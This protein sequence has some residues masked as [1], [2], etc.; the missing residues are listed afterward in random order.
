MKKEGDVISSNIFGAI[1]AFAIG[2]LLATLSYFVLKFVLRKHPKYYIAAQIFKQ[3]IQILYLF[4]LFV[5]GDKTPWDSLWLLV[6]GCLG[7]TLPMIFFT[8][9]LVKMNDSTGKGEK[10]NNG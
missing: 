7:V 9:A 8:A 4:L 3:V 6:G 2:L 5:L 10:S 1:A